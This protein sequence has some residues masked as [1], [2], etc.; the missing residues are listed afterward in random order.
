MFH[1]NHPVVT[2]LY[3]LSPPDPEAVKRR[4]EKVAAVKLAMG[5]K[6]RLAKPVKRNK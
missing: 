2:L 5:D 1:T 4:E 3:G 6:Y